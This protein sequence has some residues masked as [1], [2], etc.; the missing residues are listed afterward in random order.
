M[1]CPVSRGPFGGIDIKGKVP[2]TK[3]IDLSLETILEYADPRRRIRPHTRRRF[4]L[5][6][7][8]VLGFALDDRALTVAA[9]N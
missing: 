9:G 2:P 5:S 7:V 1:P 6:A 4:I 8:C 3:L